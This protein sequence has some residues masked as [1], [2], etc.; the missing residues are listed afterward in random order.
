MKQLRQQSPPREP[1]GL[2]AAS[3]SAALNYGTRRVVTVLGGV[4]HLSLF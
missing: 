3:V 4:S 2:S 1:D